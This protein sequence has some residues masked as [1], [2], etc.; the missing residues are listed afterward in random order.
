MI[1]STMFLVGWT[2]LMIFSLSPLLYFGVN[3]SEKSL[4]AAASMSMALLFSAVV[5]L[6]VAAVVCLFVA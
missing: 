4:D 2:G 1:T 3:T 6:V 5:Y